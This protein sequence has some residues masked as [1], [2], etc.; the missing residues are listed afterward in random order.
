MQL[1]PEWAP[2]IHPMFVHFPLALLFT[3]VLIDFFA[4]LARPW[5]WLRTVAATLYTV[6]AISAIVTY[7]T[8]QQAADLVSPP[9]EAQPILTEHADLESCL[10]AVGTKRIWL[11]SS[12]AEHRYTEAG[13]A[14]GDAL[15]FG[16]ETRGLPAAI[17]DRWAAEQRLRIP[18]VPGNRSINLSNSVAVAL[19]E[20][21]RQQGFEGG[22]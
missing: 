16:P 13:F 9:P 8:G 15:L 19:F 22:R 11:F 14:P 5:K 7:F 20:A 18:M 3:A 4:L 1:V 2:N 10:E 12:H 17:R 21:W 6:G